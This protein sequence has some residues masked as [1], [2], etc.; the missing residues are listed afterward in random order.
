LEG[1]LIKATKDGLSI[2]TTSNSSGVATFEYFGAPTIIFASK[3]GY[4]NPEPQVI[5]KIPDEWLTTRNNMYITWAIGILTLVA[6]TIRLWMKSH[7]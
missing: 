1:V 7:M 3:E 6:A 2:D 4:Y 5:P